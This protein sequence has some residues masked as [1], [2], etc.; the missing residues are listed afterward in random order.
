[1]C[2]LLGKKFKNQI[3]SSDIFFYGPTD[4]VHNFSLLDLVEKW[5]KTA[6][7]VTESKNPLMGDDL[8]GEK[9]K[10]FLVPLTES[11][12]LL[13][14]GGSWEKPALRKGNENRVFVRKAIIDTKTVVLVSIIN[15]ILVPGGHKVKEQKLVNSEDARKVAFDEMDTAMKIDKVTARFKISGPH[16][17]GENTK[18]I[19]I[20][21]KDLLNI[22]TPLDRPFTNVNQD[23]NLETD[24]KE[25]K[26]VRIRKDFPSYTSGY[27]ACFELKTPGTYFVDIDGSAPLAGH[28][29]EHED[30]ILDP[31]VIASS[32][33]H[34]DEKIFHN[35]AKYEL[36]VREA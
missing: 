23:S 16:P 4:S 36:E 8:D 21:E 5:Y 33:S 31:K 29:E 24:P 3:G 32:D 26:T 25:W 12:K 30:D 35:S 27:Y 10:N 6:L 2:P 28:Q 20:D 11:H 14:C 19:F 15:V 22:F 9:N 18:G 13:V 1:M 34:L 17:S 7:A